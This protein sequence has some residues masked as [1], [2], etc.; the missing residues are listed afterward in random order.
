MPYRISEKIYNS[1]SI[2]VTVTARNL[3]PLPHYDP[4]S[5]GIHMCEGSNSIGYVERVK[6]SLQDLTRKYMHTYI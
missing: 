2:S 1:L 6:F 5:S 4:L 3:Q